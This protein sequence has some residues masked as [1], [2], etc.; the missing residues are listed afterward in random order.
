MNLIPI[1]GSS[2]T[3]PKERL[4]ESEHHEPN[5]GQLR[6]N[7]A[8]YHQEPD[9]VRTAPSPV[10]TMG[11]RHRLGRRVNRTLS[12]SKIQFDKGELIAR[13]KSLD[14]IFTRESEPFILGVFFFT[15]ICKSSNSKYKKNIKIKRSL[16]MKIFSKLVVFKQ[17]RYVGILR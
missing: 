17:K 6:L 7:S 10:C 15:T 4:K 16:V 5:H 3:I 11:H 1:T 8:S 12:N 13:N 2:Y 9:R 14:Y